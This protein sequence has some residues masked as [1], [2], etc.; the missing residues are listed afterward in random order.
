MNTTDW[1]FARF[2]DE[3]FHLS[4]ILEIPGISEARNTLI[5]EMWKRYPQECET[6]GL[7]DGLKG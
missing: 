7:T 3:I 2:L 6:I 1:S 4:E 5:L